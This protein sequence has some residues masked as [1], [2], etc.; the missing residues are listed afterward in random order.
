MSDDYQLVQLHANGA[1]WQAT[2][3]DAGGKR[4]RK[5]LGAKSKLSR[6]DAERRCREIEARHL[7]DP[8]LRAVGRAPVLVTFARQWLETRTDLRPATRVVYGQTI[9]QLERFFGKDARLDRI[10]RERAEAFRAK[11]ERDT[12]AQSASKHVRNVKA[13][14]NAAVRLDL[15]TINPFDRVR[16]SAPKV[17]KNWRY[18]TLDE[19]DQVLD[20]CPDA[21]WRCFFGL[22]RLAGLRRG[23]ALRLTWADVDFD[24]HRLTVW[25]DAGKVSTKQR[26]RVVPIVPRLFDLLLERF[27][28]AAEGESVTDRRENNLGRDMAVIVKRA[29]LEPWSKICHTLRKNCATDWLS[30]YPAMDV[31]DWLGHS[32]EV[33]RDHYHQTRPEVLEKVTQRSAIRASLSGEL[34]QK[35]P[36]SE[37]SDSQVQ[38]R[39][40]DSN[41]R[42]RAYESLAL[43]N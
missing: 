35:L 11:L 7:A 27:E 20:A 15:A 14:C 32:P 33:A 34:P 1:Y 24:S 13:I 43:T 16:S 22:L 4:R 42:P 37:A 6:R 19:L 23:E 17:E 36:Q 40:L 21:G 18:V 28:D 3:R 5:S 8:R 12:S 31:A 30:E 39:R 25:P 9:A 2:W 29:G 26:R 41:Q 10:T 38:C